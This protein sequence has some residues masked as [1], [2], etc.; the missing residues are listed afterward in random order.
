MRYGLVM[1]CLAA[2]I[3]NLSPAWAEEAGMKITSAAFSHNGNIPSK[4]TC[5]GKNVNPPL[6]FEGVPSGVKSLALIMDDPDA[7]S[8]MFVHWVL[9]SIAPD[10]KEIA[11]DTAPK[12]AAQ[13]ITDFR[14]PGYGGPCPP[15]G[16]HRYFFKLY[17]L[18]AA[19]DLRKSAGKAD[20][21][22]AMKGHILAEAEI[23]GLYKRK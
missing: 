22:K 19:L 12:G 23:I 18:D 6:M 3:L 7:P 21:E 5:D 16:T 11:E 15:S 2:L 4:Y 14:R 10:T 13:G 17:A 9:W 8:G 20:L 1:V